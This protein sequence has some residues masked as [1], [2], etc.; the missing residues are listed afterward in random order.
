M[1]PPSKSFFFLSPIKI[2]MALFKKIEQKNH[3]TFTEPQRTANSQ[4]NF[5]EVKSRGITLPDYYIYY[6]VAIIKTA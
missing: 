5:E 6:K 3:Q 1:Q 2:L 4:S